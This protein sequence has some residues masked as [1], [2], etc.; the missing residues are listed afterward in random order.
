MLHEVDLVVV[1]GMGRAIHT[2]YGAHFKC[3]SLKVRKRTRQK[4]SNNYSKL[5][6]AVIKNEWLARRLGGELFAAVFRFEQLSG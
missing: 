3:D 1:E 4:L 6:T 2:N 5:Q